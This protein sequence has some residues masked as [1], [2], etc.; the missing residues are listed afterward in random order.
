MGIFTVS[1]AD[2]A[3]NDAF[4]EKYN[5]KNAIQKFQDGGFGGPDGNT[6][7]PGLNTDSYAT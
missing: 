7:I 2:Q 1:E 5:I 3:A 4:A 6:W